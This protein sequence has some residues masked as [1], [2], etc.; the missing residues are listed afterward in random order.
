MLTHD[1]RFTALAV[2]LLGD[3]ECQS[4]KAG[5][6]AFFGVWTVHVFAIIPNT[7]GTLAALPEQS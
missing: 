5:H 6:G 4:G 7:A 1:H 3:V 2:E